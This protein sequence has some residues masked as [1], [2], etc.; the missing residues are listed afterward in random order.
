MNKPSSSGFALGT[1]ILVIALLA[2]V[3]TAFS[4]ASR[5]NLFTNTDPLQRNELIPVRDGM[6]QIAAATRRIINSCPAD[7]VEYSACLDRINV[8]PECPECA[9]DET[10]ARHW[11]YQPIYGGASLFHIRPRYLA[12]I[13]VPVSWVLARNVRP[14]RGGALIPV[15]IY[16]EGFS[17]HACRL[18]NEI[19]SLRP[20]AATF[21]APALQSFGTLPYDAVEGCFVV[22]GTN[23]MRTQYFYVVG[24][25]Q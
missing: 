8:N 11:V 2:A 15:V 10:A 18:L 19:I 9:N 5:S 20:L 4:L 1:I 6:L 21:T 25:R 14:A 12:D 3:T 17:S 16:A 7:P 24:G 22:S 13:Q 23:G